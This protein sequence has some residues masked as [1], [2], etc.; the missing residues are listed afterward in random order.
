MPFIIAVVR[1]PFAGA[2]R[3]IENVLIADL[4]M[5]SARNRESKDEGG[6]HGADDRG[7]RGSFESPRAAAGSCENG[8][9]RLLTSQGA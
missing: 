6:K 1:Q 3:G 2:L 4:R 9:S 5:G 8:R 7:R